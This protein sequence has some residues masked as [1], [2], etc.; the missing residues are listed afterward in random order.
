MQQCVISRNSDSSLK[1]RSFYSPGAVTAVDI[2]T[3]IGKKPD[4]HHC[5]AAAAAAIANDDDD[6]ASSMAT[7]EYPRRTVGLDNNMT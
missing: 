5:N 7:E 3:K 4:S 1:T 2:E 6:F